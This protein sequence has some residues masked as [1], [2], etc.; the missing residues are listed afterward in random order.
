MHPTRRQRDCLAAIRD[1]T[2]ILGRPPTL[3]EIGFR[4]DIS[5]PCAFEHVAG[6][7]AKGLLKVTPHQ[8][9]VLMNDCCPTC[10]CE[11]TKRTKATS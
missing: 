3:R 2:L 5:A 11:L 8:A 4:M 6:L 7:R 9:G 10:G 1:L